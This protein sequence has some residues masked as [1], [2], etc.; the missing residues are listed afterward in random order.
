MSFRLSRRLLWMPAIEPSSTVLRAG[1]SIDAPALAARLAELARTGVRSVVCDVDSLVPDAAAVD[2]LARLKLA[3]RRL[4]CDLRVCRASVELHQ[5]L[6]FVGLAEA[7][8][9]GVEVVRETEQREE[10]VGVEEERE[11]GDAGS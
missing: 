4:G 3:A 6:D 11:L 7:V 1:T 5:L 10:R 2:G 9:G 8:L